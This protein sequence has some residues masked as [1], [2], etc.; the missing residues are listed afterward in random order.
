MNFNTSINNLFGNIFKPVVDTI[1]PPVCFLCDS[2]LDSNRKVVCTSCWS[3]Q[4]FLT[5]KEL[6]EIQNVIIRSNFKDINILFDFTEEFQKIIHL[7]KYERCLTLGYYFANEL[8]SKF[9]ESFFL[10]YDIIIPVPLHP[11]KY[12]ERGYNQSYEII[13]H[14]PGNKRKDLIKRKKQTQSQTKLSREERILN[15][16]E[17]FECKEYIQSLRILLFDDIITTGSTLNECGKALL[18]CGASRVDVLCL[19]APLKHV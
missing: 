19:A 15:V 16:S 8:V 5:N 12:R 3:S 18:K 7:L 4:K 10:K 9:K 13:R 6:L 2:L 14:L 17:A 11:I 1:F